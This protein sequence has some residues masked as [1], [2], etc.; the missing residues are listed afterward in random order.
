KSQDGKEE[1][2]RVKMGRKKEEESRWEGRRRKSQDGKEEGGRVKM[3][4]KKEEESR[5]EERGRCLRSSS[6]RAA[7][8]GFLH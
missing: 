7:L 3:G 2:G 4:R 6:A 5:W 8:F 1:G